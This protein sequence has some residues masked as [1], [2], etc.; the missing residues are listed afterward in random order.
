MRVAYPQQ[1]L[2]QDIRTAH[3]VA[4]DV[5]GDILRDMQDMT[6]MAKEWTIH[7]EGLEEIKISLTAKPG[8]IAAAIRPALVHI[9]EEMARVAIAVV[10][11][12]GNVEEKRRQIAAIRSN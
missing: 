9:A 4:P 8:E 6:R 12:R 5:M 10:E 11:E 7:H 3:R 2:Q 1:M